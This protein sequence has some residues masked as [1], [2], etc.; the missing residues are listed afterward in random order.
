MDKAIG[1]LADLRFFRDLRAVSE[2][3]KRAQPGEVLHATATAMQ[4]GSE[5]KK[6]SGAVPE[7]I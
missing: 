4:K 3:T 2:L 1:K 5:K 6:Q 7:V